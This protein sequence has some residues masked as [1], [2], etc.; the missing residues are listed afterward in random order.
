MKN[1][2]KKLLAAAFILGVTA[3]FATAKTYPDL[4]KKHWAYKQISALTDE[5]VLVGYPDGTFKPDEPATRAEYA[6]MVIMAL[7]QENAPLTQ[8]F[9]F[10]DVPYSH[11][12]FNTIQRAIG[13]DIL[14]NSDD[15]L[16]RPEDNII[17]ADA[18]SM[19]VNTIKTDSITEQKAQQ[20][21]SKYTDVKTIPANSIVPLGKSE[22]IGMT[23][24][25][26]IK[27][28]RFEPNRPITRAEIAANLYNM[29][30]AAR[31]N[32]NDKLAEAMKAKKGQGIVIKGVKVDGT[33]ATIPKGTLIP[34]VLM[35]S[36]SSK[37][38]EAGEVF[39]TQAD[40]NLVTKDGYILVVE[41]STVDGEITA[42]KQG[43]L[44]VRRGKLVLDTKH[45]NTVRGQTAS[46]LGNIN[47]NRNKCWLVR[48]VRAIIKG[49][50]ISLEEG[51][52]VKIK[53]EQPVKV[54]LTSGWIIENSL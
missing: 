32:P 44:F 2:I 52:V 48:I 18:I 50:N 21:L 28:L 12:S 17:K 26:P 7:H 34:V 14:K 10:K 38:N 3:N 1:V 54:D 31:Q 15:G 42:V 9:E 35:S 20:V 22:I 33:V 25:A 6:T 43:K 13:F 8:T 24:N 51:K 5:D 46:F 36:L 41:K 53:L 39:V 11:W 23:A 30:I 29:Q 40:K 37:A 47:P 49:G 4:P 45:I 19:I 27:P 16:F